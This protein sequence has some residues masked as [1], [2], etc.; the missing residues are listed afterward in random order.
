MIVIPNI[1]KPYT[2]WKCFNIDCKHWGESGYNNSDYC[3]LIEIDESE[4]EFLYKEFGLEKDENLTERAQ[5]LKRAILMGYLYAKRE[6]VQCKDCKWGDTGI[7]EEG[8]PF[9]KCIGIHYGGTKP[10]D[11]CSY[12]ERKTDE[13]YR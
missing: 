3:P 13:K 9:W 1:N 8:K 12:G 6:I 5:E 7:D 10:T 11:F 2:C 4:M